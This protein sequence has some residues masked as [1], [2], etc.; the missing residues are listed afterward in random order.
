[1]PFVKLSYAWFAVVAPILFAAAPSVR[2]L[3]KGAFTPIAEARQ[4]VIYDQPSWEKFWQKHAVNAKGV[5]QPPAVDFTREMVVAVTM[6]KQRTGGYSIEIT[7]AEVSGQ[8]FLVTVKKRVPAP[9]A[10]VTQA[11]TSPFHFAAVPLSRL[12]PVFV[13]TPEP[14]PKKG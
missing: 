1:M 10:M 13:E 5:A 14:P 7:Q 4:E 8:Q 12:K 3:A 11:F 9:G 6:G 2:T